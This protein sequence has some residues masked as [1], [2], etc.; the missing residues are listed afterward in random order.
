MKDINLYVYHANDDDPKKC[1]A[2]KLHR[3]GHVKLEQKIQRIPKN[4]ILLNP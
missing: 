1:S 3:F 2:K 4:L